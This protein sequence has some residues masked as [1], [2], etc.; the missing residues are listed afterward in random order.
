MFQKQ[1][2]IV[3]L[4]EAQLDFHQFKMPVMIKPVDSSGSK[5]ISK[6]DSIELLQEKVEYAL[7]F[8]RGKRFIIE[9]YIKKKG[10][11][12]SGDGFSV[13]GKLVFRSF[14][15]TNFPTSSVNPFV[16]IGSSWPYNSQ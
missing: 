5:G 1:K 13:D 9:E 12:V 3:V 10:S 6:L 14:A 8:S 4:E 11:L 7:L 2:D 16:P 15:N